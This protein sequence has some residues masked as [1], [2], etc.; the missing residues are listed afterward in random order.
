MTAIKT[1]NSFTPKVRVLGSDINSEVL[2]FAK[3]DVYNLED[4]E[5]LPRTIKQSFSFKRKREFRRIWYAPRS[6]QV[7][8][9]AGSCA[10]RLYGAKNQKSA[11][12]K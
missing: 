6:H 12:I 11:T 10:P 9:G 8:S 5:R 7:E 3:K 4:V 1:R 2:K